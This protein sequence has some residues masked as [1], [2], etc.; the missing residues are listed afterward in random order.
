MKLTWMGTAALLF[1]E[2]E[3]VIAFD[4]FPGIPYGALKRGGKDLPVSEK[5]RRREDARMFRRAAEVFVTHGHLDHI[6]YIPALYGGEKSAAHVT[7]TRTPYETLAGLGFPADRLREVGQGGI[8]PAEGSQH[9]EAGPF[10]LRA[11]PSRHCRFDRELILRTALSRRLLT[12]LPDLFRMGRALRSF[13][14][15]GE[16]LFWELTCGGTRVQILGSLNLRDDVDYPSG[17]DVLIL[18]YQGKSGRLLAETA[19]EI[20]GRLRPKSVLLDHYDDT[21]PPLSAD[22]PTGEIVRISE[23]RFGIPCRPLKKYEAVLI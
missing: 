23:Q 14:E 10:M 6:C 13:P 9:V 11:W 21:F 3:H 19:S 16:T 2:A 8:V 22:V 7:C 5:R 18:P 20:I 12:H 15:A 1:E 17:A 4:P